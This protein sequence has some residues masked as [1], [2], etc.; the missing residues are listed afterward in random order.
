MRIISWPS[1]PNADGRGSSLTMVAGAPAIVLLV[2]LVIP[3]NSRNWLLMHFKILLI[4]ASTNILQ[5][6][7]GKIISLV[8]VTPSQYFFLQSLKIRKK[9][10]Y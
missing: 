6:L 4:F 9:R 7:F 8:L 3:F 10:P 1:V 5:L 2:S